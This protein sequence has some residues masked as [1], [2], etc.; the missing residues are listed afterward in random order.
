LNVKSFYLIVFSC[1][2]ILS[3]CE[4]NSS[5]SKEFRPSVR[6]IADELNSDKRMSD[7]LYTIG[8]EE[9]LAEENGD[10]DWYDIIGSLDNSFDQLPEEEQYEFLSKAQDIIRELL[11]GE[12]PACRNNYS[13]QIRDIAF[14]TSDHTY[15]MSFEWSGNS[16]LKVDNLIAYSP[17]E[18][19][20]NNEEERQ[21]EEKSTQANMEENINND[22]VKKMQE[23]AI[24]M[25]KQFVDFSEAFGNPQFGD[26]DW[27]I[28]LAVTITEISK[29]SDQPKEIYPP[30]E[31][32]ETHAIYLEAMND[33]KTA[34]AMLPAA[35]DN[36][37]A[38]KINEAK[39]Y[40]DKA[41]EKVKLVHAKLI[42]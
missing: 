6:I 28:D 12:D 10:I 42:P 30:S 21:Q 5:D 38:Y 29:L 18:E 3:G 33:Y 7:Y 31:Y 17:K 24:N 11:N 13:C 40:M 39:E 1:F 4:N 37:D 41:L 25:Q 22:Y 26:T 2:A 20:E 35:L 8:Y 9:S 15:T 23:H 14:Y 34:M 16:S 19:S 36:M 32:E 27:M